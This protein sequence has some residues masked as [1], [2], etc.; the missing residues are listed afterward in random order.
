MV[1]ARKI[2]DNGLSE[3]SKTY[4]PHGIYKKLEHCES[5]GILGNITEE[6]ENIIKKMIIV[7][8]WCT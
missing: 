4:F 1:G 6:E 8:L 7:S 3:T 5:F 2:F